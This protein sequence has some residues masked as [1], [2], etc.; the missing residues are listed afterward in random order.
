MAHA[1]YQ[2]ANSLFDLLLIL[3]LQAWR[4]QVLVCIF[5][6]AYV[7]SLHLQVSVVE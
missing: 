5:E 3:H 2:H 7:H 4:L 1:E 6:H